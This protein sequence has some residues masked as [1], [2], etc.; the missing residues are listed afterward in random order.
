MLID[1]ACGVFELKDI[2]TLRMGEKIRWKGNT[3]KVK[4]EENKIY[5][6]INKFFFLLIDATHNHH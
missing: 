2:K 5:I 1:I 3:G 4:V 6:I